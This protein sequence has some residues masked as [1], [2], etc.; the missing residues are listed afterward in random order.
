LTSKI[1]YAADYS[2]KYSDRRARGV[3]VL[4]SRGVAARERSQ[5]SK[6]VRPL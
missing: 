3:G 1:R 5:I 2:E 4:L 6:A